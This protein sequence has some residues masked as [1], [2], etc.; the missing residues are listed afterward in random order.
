M[1]FHCI[2]I[3]GEVI[4]LI[5]DPQTSISRRGRK[6]WGKLMGE[7]KAMALD[8]HLATGTDQHGDGLFLKADKWGGAYWLLW[9]WHDSDENKDK[10]AAKAIFRDVARPYHR[11]KLACWIV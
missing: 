9:V 5:A 4:G 1:I 10:V 6:I 7:L 3:L 2:S 11:R 8:A